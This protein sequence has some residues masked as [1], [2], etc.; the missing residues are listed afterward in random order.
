VSPGLVL[1]TDAILAYVEGTEAVGE[2]LAS[3]ADHGYAVL[4]PATCLAAAYQRVENEGWNYLDVLASLD[5]ALVAPL[6]H[7][8]CPVLGRWARNLGLDTAHAAIEAASNPV[9]PLMT[10]RR[11]LVTRFLPGSGRSSMSDRLV[12]AGDRG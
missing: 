4:I 11:D 8:Q 2:H 7:E 9:V 3:A 12:R 6:T 1:D 5:H 10:S